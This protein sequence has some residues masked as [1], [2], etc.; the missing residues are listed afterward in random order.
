MEKL[1]ECQEEFYESTEVAKKF[2][3]VL[4]ELR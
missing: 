4:V 1:L 3:L 2:Q